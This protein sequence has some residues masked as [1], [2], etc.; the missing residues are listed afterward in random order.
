[1]DQTTFDLLAIRVKGFIYEAGTMLVL[2]VLA[3]LTSPDFQALVT[4]HFGESLTSSIILLA[5]SGIVKHV[6][7][8]LTLNAAADTLGSFRE[9]KQHVT[10]I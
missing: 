10:L 2:A 3:A 1:M 4:Q 5:V 8:V 9:A 7:N 6:R